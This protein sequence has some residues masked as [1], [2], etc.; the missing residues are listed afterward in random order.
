M[1]NTIKLK[2]GSGSDPSAS[3]LVVG[4]VA[5]RTD[6]GKLFTKKDDN[7]V[8]EI[9]VTALGNNDVTTSTIADDAV[10]YA[11]IQ[12]VSATNKILG[13]VSSGA[14][15]IEELSDSNIRTLINVADGST[16]NAKASEAEVQTGSN[17]AKFVTPLQ[18]AQ[19]KQRVQ[20]IDVSSLHSTV[21]AAKIQHD[22]GTKQLRVTAQYKGNDSNYEEVIIDWNTTTDGTTESN[23]YIYVQFAA[24]PSYDITVCIT[25]LENAKAATGITYPTS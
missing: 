7:S 16:A 5:I 11:K 1:S 25:S 22:L 6:T 9:G 2:T 18:L 13:R 15:I 3:D 8:A 12:N 23:D 4:E 19:A 21:L 14:G 10:T 20:V 17:D 24:V